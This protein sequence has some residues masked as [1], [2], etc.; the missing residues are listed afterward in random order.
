[1]TRDLLYLLQAEKKEAYWNMKSLRFSTVLVDEYGKT[2]CISY[3]ENILL[4]QYGK[5][6]CYLL[7]PPF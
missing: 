7:Q 1:M 2:F 3:V 4:D 5:D 6:L